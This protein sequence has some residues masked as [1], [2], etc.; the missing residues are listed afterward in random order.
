[1]SYQK[2]KHK[3]SGEMYIARLEDGNLVE[4]AGPLA[5]QEI[6]A[7]NPK[8]DIINTDPYDLVWAKEHEADFTAEDFG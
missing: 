4:F 2:W 5:H 8:T 3:P 1:M 6:E 7:F